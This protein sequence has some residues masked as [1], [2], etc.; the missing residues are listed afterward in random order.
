MQT[1]I[2]RIAN[3]WPTIRDVFSVP[4]TEDEYENLVSFLD[5]LIDEIGENEDHPLS[6]LMETIGNLIETYEKDNLAQPM[7]SPAE[8][9]CYLMAEH[10]LK[11]S[12]L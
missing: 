4:H 10:G 7:S 3:V 1:Q 9:L 8:T 6:A 2:Q 11:Q 12:D 5:A